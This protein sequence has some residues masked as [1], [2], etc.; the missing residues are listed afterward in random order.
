MTAQ[1]DF[2]DD[3]KKFYTDKTSIKLIDVDLSEIV[4]SNKWKINDTT[5]KYYIGYK[6]DNEIKPLCVIMPQMTGYIKY[7][8]DG[9]KNMSFIS[10]CEYVYDKYAA[11]WSRIEKLLKLNFSVNPIRDDKYVLCCKSK[12]INNNVWTT[13]S[14]DVVPTERQSYLC[15]AAIDNDSVLKVIKQSLS[16]SLF[17]TMQVQN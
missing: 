15:I 16:A 13:F 7:F 11:I 6:N 14:N 4:V 8:D 9:G 5:C 12:I 17:R 3:K 2:G 10:D 1:I